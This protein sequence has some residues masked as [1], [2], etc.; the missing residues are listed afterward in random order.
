MSIRSRTADP[1]RAGR[2]RA[3]IVRVCAGSYDGL[4]K[5]RARFRYIALPA[6][7]TMSQST[8]AAIKRN[9]SGGGDEFNGDGAGAKSHTDAAPTP[10]PI[11]NTTM[12]LTRNRL[13]GLP[14]FPIEPMLRPQQPRKPLPF[15]CRA[16]RERPTAA[17]CRTTKRGAG[18]WRKATRTQAENS[19]LP[20]N[21]SDLAFAIWSSDH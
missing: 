3:G 17:I 19:A 6:A 12:A 14:T 7:Y 20:D 18:C 15:L 1:S 4:A 16:C 10:V 9:G 13:V 2:L 21:K 11:A 5:R 8:N